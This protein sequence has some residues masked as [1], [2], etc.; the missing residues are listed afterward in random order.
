M[1]A[2]IVEIRRGIISKYFIIS[3]LLTIVVCMSG[4]CMIGGKQNTIYEL[5]VR[6]GYQEMDFL[7]IP[8]NVLCR[9]WEAEFTL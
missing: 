9:Y 8:I 5:F 3:I 6:T 4:S 7:S 2:I 1:R